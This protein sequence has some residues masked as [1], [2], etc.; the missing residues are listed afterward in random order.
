[1]KFICNFLVVLGLPTLTREICAC[2]NIP[3][4]ICL[5]CCLLWNGARHANPCR[6]QRLG[7]KT[8]CV[9]VILIMCLTKNVEHEDTEITNVSLLIIC[10]V[11]RLCFTSYKLWSGVCN[12]SSWDSGW[13]PLHLLLVELYIRAVVWVWWPVCH[14]GP[15]WDCPQLWSLCPLLQ[16]SNA[17]TTFVICVL[18]MN[19][20]QHMAEPQYNQNL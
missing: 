6:L 11:D 2:S 13:W 14:P 19:R 3:G 18:Y 7:W 10:N 4:G 17:D 16:V 8:V 12:L 9:Q 15:T 20:L 1:M 5:F